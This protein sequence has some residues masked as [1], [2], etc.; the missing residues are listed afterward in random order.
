MELIDRYLQAVKFW[1]PRQQKED[2]IAELSADIYAQIDE[3]ET[4]LS[5][6]LNDAEVE[7]LLKQRGHPLLV[8]NRFLP[9]E[10]LIGPVLFP[11]YRFVLKIFVYGYLLPSVLVWMGLMIFSSSYRL[12]QTNP[13]WFTAFS[14][15]FNY[16]W[17]T[18]FLAA[19]TITLAF[20]VLERTQARIHIFDRWNPRKLPPVRNPY[21]IPR[22][23]S[24]FELA[25]SLIFFVW[26]AVYLHS[27]VVPI[28]LKV[29]IF[30]NPQWLWFFWGYL[31]LALVNASLAGL[32]LL[33]PSWT[34]RRAT[35]RLLSDSAGAALFCWLMKANLLAGITGANLPVQQAIAIAQAVNDWMSRLF[36]AAI[37][38]GLVIVATDVYRIVRMKSAGRT[39]P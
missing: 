7:E 12:E 38:V 24:L 6:K 22:S 19:G 25:V 28:G 31:L 30:L 23:T 16:L 4:V 39:T 13:S 21:L 17:F 37:V 29:T 11:I 20:A 9:Q 33:Y 15:L 14:S 5:R 32:N 26:F 3:R 8:A 1:L 36:P 34:A 10:S 27:P 18:T 2:I 35:L